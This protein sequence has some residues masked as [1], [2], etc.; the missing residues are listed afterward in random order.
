MYSLLIFSMKEI[1]FIDLR[2]LRHNKGSKQK[3]DGLKFLRI[4][5]Y[6]GQSRALLIRKRQAKHLVAPFFLK[7][8]R[9]A[10]GHQQ[11]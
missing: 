10:G 5:R 4:G 3:L 2:H 7:V 8:E 11:F 6:P 9:F 1:I